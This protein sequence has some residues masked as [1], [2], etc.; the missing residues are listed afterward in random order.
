[1]L[2]KVGANAYQSESNKLIGNKIQTMLSKVRQLEL[3]TFSQLQLSCCFLILAN[4]FKETF[5]DS[6]IYRVWHWKKAPQN[7]HLI[8]TQTSVGWLTNNPGILCCKQL[9]KPVMRDSSVFREINN[10]QNVQT[11]GAKETSLCRLSFD[12]PV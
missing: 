1:M 10:F 3:Y 11:S 9:W 5:D 7:M 12:S 6:L 4:L 2:L 8:Q